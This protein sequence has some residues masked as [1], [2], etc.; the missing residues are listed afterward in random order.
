MFRIKDQAL[1]PSRRI[2]PLIITLTMRRRQPKA[3]SRWYS[4]SNREPFQTK[5]ISL[6]A[7]CNSISCRNSSKMISTLKKALLRETSTQMESMMIT[8]LKSK[9][10]AALLYR[11]GQ[12]DL[13]RRHPRLKCRTLRCIMMEAAGHWRASRNKRLLTTT[14][15]RYSSRNQC[16]RLDLNQG[17]CSH[18]LYARLHPQD[19]P[20]LTLQGS[21]LASGKA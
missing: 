3:P 21:D 12:E 6:A 1:R 8:T 19:P 2:Q 11:I 17:S 20:L 14:L 9:T 18:R 7:P 10:K 16:N 5:G 15:H 4:R 13:L